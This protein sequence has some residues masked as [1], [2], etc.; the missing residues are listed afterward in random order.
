MEQALLAWAAAASFVQELPGVELQGVELQEAEFPLA[1]SAVFAAQLVWI[2]DVAA[3]DVIVQALQAR[4][5]QPG[6]RMVDLV[7]YLE[8]CSLPLCSAGIC[9][10]CL[11]FH[12][13]FSA[14]VHRQPQLNSGIYLFFLVPAHVS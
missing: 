5:S 12:P 14:G 8:E 3:T 1:D 10:S 13:A 2:S 9:L 6:P 4:W 7:N 11:R